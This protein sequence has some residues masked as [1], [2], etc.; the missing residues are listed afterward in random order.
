MIR[1]NILLFLFLSATSIF[2]QDNYRL[3]GK[4]NNAENVSIAYLYYPRQNEYIVDSCYIKDNRFNFSGF[5]EYPV[6]AT[7]EL[8]NKDIS[9]KNN[10]GDVVNFYL[11]NGSIAINIDRI[12]TRAT[13]TG[14]HT[15]D[16]HIEFLK[17]LEP[18]KE[19]MNSIHN[20]YNNATKEQLASQKF[21]DSLMMRRQNVYDM[22]SSCI[23]RFVKEHPGDFISLYLLQT[24]SDNTPEDKST[25]NLFSGLSEAIRNTPLGKSLA[26]KLQKQQAVSIGSPAPEFECKDIDGKTVKLSD[27][28][29]KYL[30]LMFW[31]SDCG[32]CQDE[33][34]SI[35]KA[36]KRFAGKEF[37]ILAVAQ[38]V[39]DRKNDWAEFVKEKNLPWIN[40]FDERV[41]GKKKLAQLYNV[42][43]IPS[44]FLLDTRGRIIAK[45]LY[46]ES[47]FERLTIIE[48]TY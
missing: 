41:N 33:L 21:N 39:M 12:K 23:Y 26:D 13:V 37:T 5:V 36:Y 1:F 48:S 35:E 29:G 18:L 10:Q 44:N 11:E 3:T 9:P 2:A 24:Q 32:H 16:L 17:L 43:R 42:Q 6:L 25:I 45:D 34:P 30:L 14:S 40:I 4:V 27:F 46:G 8:R 38:D 7:L 15:H 19:E 31:S 20:A 28:K 22:N 47:L